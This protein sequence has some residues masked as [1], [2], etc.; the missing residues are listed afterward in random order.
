MLEES[1]RGW[2]DPEL[3]PL[4]AQTEMQTKVGREVAWPADAAMQESLENMRRQ[5]S[6]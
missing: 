6:Q 1:Q 2:R 3:I 5:L 4:F